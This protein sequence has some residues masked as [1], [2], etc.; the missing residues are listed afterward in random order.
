MAG[1]SRTGRLGDDWRFWPAP[2][3][4]MWPAGWSAPVTSPVSAGGYE[5]ATQALLLTAAKELEQ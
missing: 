3:P 4:G 2:R 1:L 5:H